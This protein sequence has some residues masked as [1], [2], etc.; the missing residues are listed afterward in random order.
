MNMI[1]ALI[2]AIDSIHGPG[3]GEYL[4][5]RPTRFPESPVDLDDSDFEPDP[6]EP[7]DDFQSEA[8]A[9][10]EIWHD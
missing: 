3:T 10:D 2:R 9:R 4:R 1:D 6:Y 5:T 8:D 7:N